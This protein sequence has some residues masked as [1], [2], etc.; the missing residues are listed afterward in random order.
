MK[1][2]VIVFLILGLLIVTGLVFYDWA[3][4]YLAAAAMAADLTQ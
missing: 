4:D 1:K 2:I 3:G